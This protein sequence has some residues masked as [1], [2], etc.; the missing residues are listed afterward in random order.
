MNGRSFIS[1]LFAK[2]LGGERDFLALSLCGC[3]WLAE[4]IRDS[5][6]NFWRCS[7]SFFCLFF[8]IFPSRTHFIFSID[9]FSF[10]SFSLSFLRR[11][12]GNEWKIIHDH[13]WRVFYFISTFSFIFDRCSTWG[14]LVVFSICLAAPPPFLFF[15]LFLSGS[16]LKTDVSKVTEGR[17][18][19]GILNDGGLSLHSRATLLV[20]GS[21]LFFFHFLVFLSS[22][23]SWAFFPSPSSSLVDYFSGVPFGSPS[24]FF[25]S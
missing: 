2:G 15:G 10:G 23:L 7:L 24:P 6:L 20:I 13:L 16:F 21:I 17:S 8:W 14:F 22:S 25:W 18:M 4:I 5:W 19:D 12:G 11:N 3:L 1:G 9:F